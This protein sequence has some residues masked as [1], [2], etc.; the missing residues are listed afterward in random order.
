MEHE[1]KDKIVVRNK[2]GIKTESSAEYIS[3]HTQQVSQ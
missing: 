3:T 2:N 1:K